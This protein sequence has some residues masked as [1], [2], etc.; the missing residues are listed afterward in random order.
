MEECILLETSSAIE[1]A[2][3]IPKIKPSDENIQEQKKLIDDK[4]GRGRAGET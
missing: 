2:S 1:G 3:T 4:M